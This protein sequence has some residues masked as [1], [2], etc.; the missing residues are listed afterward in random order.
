MQPPDEVEPAG[1]ERALEAALIEPEC[2]IFHALM[3]P[4]TGDH[5]LGVRHAGNALGIDEGDDLDMLEPGR[6]ERVDERDL[7]RGRDRPRLDL[8][9]LARTLLLDRRSRRHVGHRG[10]P[11]RPP[12]AVGT[13]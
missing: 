1:G 9:A 10:S 5:R 13:A 6:R 3:A 7:A 2:H 8:E 4:V 11:P 12:V